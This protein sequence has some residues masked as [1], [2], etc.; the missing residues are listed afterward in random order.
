MQ[1]TRTYKSN[2]KKITDTCVVTVRVRVLTYIKYFR[3]YREREEYSQIQ[4]ETKDRC[5]TAE[6]FKQLMELIASRVKKKL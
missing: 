4:L 6:L 5:A 1:Q 3:S 2:L